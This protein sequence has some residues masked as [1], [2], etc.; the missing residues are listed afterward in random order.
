[1]TDSRHVENRQI[2]ICHYDAERVSQAYRPFTILPGFKKR[3]FLMGGTLVTH[4]FCIITPN[5]MEIGRIVA[6]V[7]RFFRVFQVKCK[8]SLDDRT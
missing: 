7:S 1:M 6:E 2:A 4:M 3:E 8:N 5:C